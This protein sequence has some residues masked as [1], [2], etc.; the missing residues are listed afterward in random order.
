[1][2]RL[3]FAGLA[4]EIL[5][6]MVRRDREG[7]PCNPFLQP[8][9]A[10]IERLKNIEE[11]VEARLEVMKQLH[12]WIAGIFNPPK[13]DK[14]DSPENPEVT[15]TPPESAKPEPAPEPQP[16]S[17]PKPKRKQKP[18]E[19]AKPEYQRLPKHRATGNSCLDALET[20]LHDAL[21]RLV[22]TKLAFY[23]KAIKEVRLALIELY[24]AWDKPEEE[25]LAELEAGLKEAA[26]K[27]SGN[28]RASKSKI[29]QDIWSGIIVALQ[30]KDNDE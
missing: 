3:I 11:Q 9:E 30:Q 25:R 22:N 28:S 1:M 20:A 4:D 15:K 12:Q 13:S 10:E 23:V 2:L 18:K 21:E 17:A 5:R 6:D 16:I 24:K 19:K 27:L 7:K 26:D 14:T 29:M 8:I